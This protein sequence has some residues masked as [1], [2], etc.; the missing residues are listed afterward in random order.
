MRRVLDLM[1]VAG[2]VLAAVALAG[3]VA[4]MLLNSALR[5]AGV[6]FRGADEIVGYLCAASGFLALAHT[7]RH[8]EL[9]RVRL[10]IDLL[11]PHTRRIAEILPLGDAV[12]IVGYI[13]WA[14]ARFV[15]ESWK[16]GEMGTGM[17]LIPIW[18][19]QMSLVF[20]AF[21]LAVA[22]VD[23]FVV[24]ITGGTPVYL[25]VEKE[26]EGSVDHLTEAP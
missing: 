18:I 12:L 22:V 14:S 3:M 17:L 16:L 9:V 26:R 1:Y 23:D 7:F 20:G 4:V 5:E 15:Y 6:H 19:P 21:V 11:P 2:G 25:A 10:L 8:G 13:L 24:L